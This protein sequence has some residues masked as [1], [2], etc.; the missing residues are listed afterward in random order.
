MNIT[1]DAQEPRTIPTKIAFIAEAPSDEEEDALKPLVGPSGRVFNAALRSAGLDRYDYAVGN[2]FNTKLPDNSVRNWCVPMDVARARGLTDI[3]PIGNEGFLDAQY[4]WHLDRLSEEIRRWQPNVVVPLGGTALWAFT[5]QTQIMSHRGTA[6]VATRLAPGVKVFPTIHPAAVIHQWKFFTVF[7]G[8]LIKAAAQ[9]EFPEVR[10]PKRE[11]TLEPTLD[12][13]WAYLPRLLA[14]SLLSV[15]IE[16]GWGQITNIGFAPDPEHALNVPFVDTRSINRSYWPSLR[17][18]REALRFV[19][20][21][22][23]SDVPKLGQ[24]YGGYDATVLLNQWRMGTHNLLHDTRLMHHA[25]YPELPKS[26]EFM[27][28][29]YA[30]QG[31]WKWMGRK[32]QKEK[33]DD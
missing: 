28:N 5:G 22:L 3:P 30:T 4:R 33:R 23:E 7:I 16:T 19:R 13:L 1:V 2:V 15:D 31:A 9:A 11:L 10:R 17:E 18:E 25:L 12:D 21:V 32:S 27:G 29:S 20:T 6:T 24:N 14:S 26:L 8:D